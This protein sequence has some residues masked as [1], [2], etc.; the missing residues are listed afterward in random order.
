ML[1]VLFIPAGGDQGVAKI[2]AP[3]ATAFWPSSRPLLQLVLESIRIRS[4]VSPS[5]LGVLVRKRVSMLAAVTGSRDAGF[6]NTTPPPKP[7]ICWRASCQSTTQEGS[8][9]AAPRTEADNRRKPKEAF[10]DAEYGVPTS[11]ER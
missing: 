11:P 4:K 5:W 6:R 1:F 10:R 9:P 7:S 8:A 2:L 3:R